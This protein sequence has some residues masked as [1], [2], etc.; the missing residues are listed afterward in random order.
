MISI[1]I[2]RRG[3]AYIPFS[4]EDRKAGLVFPENQFLHAK[5]AGSKKE[6]HYKQLC[7]YFGSCEYIADLAINQNMNT[8]EKVDHL[9]RLRCGFVEGTVFDERGL[10][11]WLVKSLSYENCD[12]PDRTAFITQAL[13]E[14]AALAGV[15]DIKTYLIFLK[16]LK[17]KENKIGRKNPSVAD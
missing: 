9:T 15:D 3:S 16:N 1:C 6:P 14:H 7:A 5:I 13:E 10:L 4:E 2:Q 17:R 8:K 11:H 12:Q